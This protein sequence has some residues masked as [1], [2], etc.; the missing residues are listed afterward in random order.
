ML[1]GNSSTYFHNFPCKFS[2]Y[3]KGK[4]QKMR[5]N[6]KVFTFVKQKIGTKLWFM[7]YAWKYGSTFVVRYSMN[8][9]QCGLNE[10]VKFIMKRK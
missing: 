9:I 5:K 10:K 8:S 4:V 1:N 3:Q 6:R 7:I 2:T